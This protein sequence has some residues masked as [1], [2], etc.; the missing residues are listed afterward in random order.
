MAIR[1]LV[2]P[3]AA[4]ACPNHLNP[5]ATASLDY[6]APNAHRQWDRFIE[7]L[8]CAGDVTLV[9]IDADDSA[10]DLVFT[11]TAALINDNLA[12]LSSPRDPARRR[13]RDRYRE[14]LVGAGLAATS[15]QQTYFEGAADTLF[16]RVRPLCYAAYHRREERSAFLELQELVD[17][18]I[19]PLRFADERY[20][21]LDTALCPLGSGHVLAYLPAFCVHAQQLLRRAVEPEYLIEVGAEDAAALACSAVEV[22]A[23]LV[24][25]SA[26]RALRERLNAAGYRVFCTDLGEFVAAGGSAK[27]LTLRLDD[28]PVANR[29]S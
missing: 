13:H 19:L 2:S 10:P 6:S 11:G 20:F 15:L 4:Q 5:W 17:C 27:N 8:C 25:H 3:P 12:V 29:F 9:D 14:A 26:T 22:G 7:T 1:F 28:G 16:D 18:R 23:S 24:L 21:H